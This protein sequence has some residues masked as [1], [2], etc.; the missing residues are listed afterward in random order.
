MSTVWLIVRREFN[1]RV[2]GKGFL[3]ITFIGLLAIVGLAFAPSLINS[4]AGGKQLRLVVADR[5]GKSFYS[6]LRA[7]LVDALP[8]G[9]LR[10]VLSQSSAPTSDL[11]AQVQQGVADG[12]ILITSGSI[13]AG[14]GPTT[15]AA[16]GAGAGAGQAYQ[17]V[18]ATKSALA[19]ND[20]ARLQ[21]ALSSAAVF[22]RLQDKGIA[23]QDVAQLFAPVAVQ[24]QV[25]SGKGPQPAKTSTESFALTYVLVLLL[26][27]TV[28]VYGSYVALGV[29][30]EK[31]SRV[32]EILLSAARPFQL[33]IGKVLGVGLTALVQYVI[34]LAAGGAVL[35]LR[36]SGM[37]V[38]VGGL[39]VQL[40]AVD[41]WV[42]LAFVVFFLLGFFSY[43][44]LFAA[45]GSLVSRTE[46][47][48]QISTPVIL[49][50]LVIFIIAVWAL[51]NPDRPLAVVLSMVP[52]ASPIMM[53]VRIGVD[54]PPLWQVAVAVV[55]NLGTI[56][57]LIW[58]AAK[59]FR[60]GVLLYGR[61]VGLSAVLKALR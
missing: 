13:G 20:E 27:M 15:G 16:T 52:L 19:A 1:Y 59:V 24:T 22:V 51:S 26:Y 38:N 60:A 4:A 61:R 33:M 31:S 48:Q 29:I 57:A 45:G 21:A 17:S 6:R 14:T 12:Y 32:V 47:A 8:G 25:I 11:E 56:G 18:V 35:L 46:D 9:E 10:Y 54:S 7:D 41:P 50:L 55:V 5:T 2:R 44:A 42:L 40:S 43:A 3:L 23:G 37:A 28:A 58:L 30:E 49:P 53:F 39:K 34:W 36:G